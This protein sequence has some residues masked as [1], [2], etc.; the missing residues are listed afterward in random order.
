MK[1]LI[2]SSIFIL[3]CFAQTKSPEERGAWACRTGTWHNCKCP[4]MVAE[5]YEEATRACELEGNKQACEDRKR[6]PCEV[7]QKPDTK[8]PEH[9]CGRSCTKAKCACHDGPMCEGPELKGYHN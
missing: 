8:H 1:R 9:T 4:A 3:G 7:I 6:G 2:L 5:A